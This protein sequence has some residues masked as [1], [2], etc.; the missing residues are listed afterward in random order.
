VRAA[1]ERA[2]GGG[3]RPY[4][5]RCEHR[6]K[7]LGIGER[8]PGA[9]ATVHVPVVGAGAS[10]VWEG[11]TPGWQSPGVEIVGTEEAAAG[12]R[13]LVYR[14]ESGDYRFLARRTG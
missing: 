13:A 10:S 14:V 9:T 6:T 8:A 1:E 12:G 7:P 2:I 3:L 11:E 4:A 5:L